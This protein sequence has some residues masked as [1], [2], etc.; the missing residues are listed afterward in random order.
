MGNVL[1]NREKGLVFVL[2]APAG[3]GK[4]TL[5]R[6]LEEEFPCILSS[7]S[8]TTRLPR[9]GE[10]DGKDYHFIKNDEFERMIQKGLFLEY[11]KL[12]DHYY[13]T[14]KQWVLDQQQQGKHVVLVIDTQGAMRLKG[15]FP[16]VFIFIQPPSLEELEK[17]L[18]KR[19]TEPQEVVKK[20]LAWAKTELETAHY[21]DYQIINEDLETAYTVLKSIFIAEEHRVI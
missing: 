12:Y 3:T 19:K 5:V 8:Y 20:R 17:R 4:T 1:G 15:S 2:S 18:K 10:V 21:Y 6:K 14:S 16:A 11:V 13:G 7:I 9:Q